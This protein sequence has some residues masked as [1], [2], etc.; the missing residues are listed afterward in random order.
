[1]FTE[2][3]LIAIDETLGSRSTCQCGKEL[4]PV[5]DSTSL[6]LEC[7]VYVEDH[8]LPARLVHFLE[9]AFHD[10]HLIVSR[11]AVA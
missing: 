1:M 2:S 6:W 8:R 11:Q 10:R 5:E 4:V 7:P 3:I 9:N